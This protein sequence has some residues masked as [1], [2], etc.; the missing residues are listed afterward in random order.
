MKIWQNTVRK[1]FLQ[2]SRSIRVTRVLAEKNITR[3]FKYPRNGKLQKDSLRDELKKLRQ[4]F[5]PQ[6]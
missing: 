3:E 6:Q 1:S 4:Q 2:L 5:M